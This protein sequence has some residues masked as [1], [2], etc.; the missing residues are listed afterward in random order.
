MGG[1]Q[2][3]TSTT[4]NVSGDHKVNTKSRNVKYTYAHA[5]DDSEEANGM[6]R[7]SKRQSQPVA[8]K[9]PPK[10]RQIN[11]E[12]LIAESGYSK[13]IENYKEKE[14]KS[15]QKKE[16]V[17]VRDPKVETSDR[18]ES[19][20]EK[21]RPAP[22]IEKGD[23]IPLF[24]SKK[25]SETKES[26]KGVA[27]NTQIGGDKQEDDQKK[28]EEVADGEV[29]NES[30]EIEYYEHQLEFNEEDSERNDSGSDYDSK[31]E[32]SRSRSTSRRT[33]RSSV[34]SDRNHRRSHS[35]SSDDSTITNG[36]ERAHSKARSKTTERTTVPSDSEHEK[37]E[38]DHI[39]EHDKK[40]YDND[41]ET[42][43]LTSNVYV[44]PE[45]KAHKKETKVDELVPPEENVFVI[46]LF[47]KDKQDDDT[48]KKAS[49]TDAPNV[50]NVP[51][52]TVVKDDNS[53]LNRHK[54]NLQLYP[55][56]EYYK[57]VIRLDKE[58]E[59]VSLLK[60][61]FLKDAIIT[62]GD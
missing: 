25:S 61:V 37:E 59:D 60:D 4:T 57:T 5:A 26:H 40:E 33:S 62:D 35:S 10:K 41:T 53:S 13:N 28:N 47:E 58:T 15:M 51:D 29:N 7:S 30:G 3:T 46:H 48:S 9:P 20:T 44:V 21:I 27:S 1:T 55:G 34:H 43:H 11:Y 14:R 17:G 12:Q 19:R 50:G 32:K 56:V 16:T 38:S 6:K 42:D 24:P 2:S 22:P 18:K 49:C 8:K 36:S 52:E 39:N 31:S 45:T 54:V 23:I